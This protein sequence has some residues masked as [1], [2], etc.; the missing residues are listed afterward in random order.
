MSILQ[1]Y[2]EIRRD[3]GEKKFDSIDEYLKTICPNER[4]IDYNKKV[5]KLIRDN[6][7]NWFDKIDN[8]KKNM[9]ITMLDDVLYKKEEWMKYNV[10]YNQNKLNR[11]LKI[12]TVY[13]TDFDDKRV[14]AIL[15]ENNKEIANIIYS[16][17]DT[18]DLYPKQDGVIP[19][20]ML[21]NMLYDNWDYLKNL[22]KIT[23]CSK[24]LQH[25]YKDVKE[26]ET[27][28]YFMDKED[29]EWYQ[30]KYHDKN[31]LVNLQKDID[32][33]GL[34]NVLEINNNDY[35]ITVYGDFETMFNDDRN[36]ERLKKR[37]ER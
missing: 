33:Y 15:Y 31:A 8:L 12:L 21:E 17:E 11:S 24:L 20:Y 14:N 10:W 25:I 18:I 1:E 36:L 37:E 9:N 16:F 22:P 13:D 29:F 34:K 4:I 6:P 26:G 7:D 3:M 5:N 23:K 28:M 32:K 19:G 30:E 27:N 35:V 2:E